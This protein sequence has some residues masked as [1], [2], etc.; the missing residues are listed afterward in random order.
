MSEVIAAPAAADAPA[1]VQELALQTVT[2]QVAEFNTI[3]AGLAELAK[4]Y[5]GVAYDVSTTKGMDEAKQARM[6]IREVRYK[7]QNLLTATKKPLNDIKAQVDELAK[8]IIA[9]I[10][11]IEEP[12]D[13]QIKAEEQRKADEKA[14][15]ER[16]EAEARA[17]VQTRIDAIRE[18]LVRASGATC[19]ELA[20]M[21]AEL[22]AMDISLE[23]YGDRTGE[24]LQLRNEVMSKMVALST[25]E[26]ERVMREQELARQE[27]ELAER[28]AAF[29]AEQEA[30]RKAQ[31]EREAAE[32]DERNRKARIQEHLDDL[33]KY[34][35]DAAAAKLSFTIALL[36]DELG[37]LVMT[38]AIFGER[39]SEAE[40]TRASMLSDMR[41]MYEAAVEHEAAEHKREQERLARE[42]ELRAEAERLAKVSA[43][44]DDLLHACRVSVA[45][46]ADLN[47]AD[48]IKGDDVGAM[49]MRQ[50]A[51][52]A[53]QIVFN[54]LTK[55]GDYQ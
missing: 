1:I 10:E 15:R 21:G 14:A 20:D 19:Q 35:R 22:E 32:L 49:D 4:R 24:A 9:R 31:A 7:A 26:A 52:A 46:L 44:A 27:A 29:E 38:E 50:R 8:R 28:R 42:A 2:N 43:A 51:K 45:Y 39:V 41:A 37:G 40:Q 30:A 33:Q 13:K 23:L 17:Q 53:Q 48:W 25:A 55:A 5:Q 54:A 47:G 16:A 12:I 11:A 34:R 3:E 6:A 18:F 36:I